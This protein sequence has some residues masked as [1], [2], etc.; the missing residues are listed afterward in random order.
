MMLHCFVWSHPTLCWFGC[1][2][3]PHASSNGA[4]KF[5]LGPPK[6]LFIAIDPEPPAWLLLVPWSASPAARLCPLVKPSVARHSKVLM[7]APCSGSGF[8]DSTLLGLVHP[9]SARQDNAVFVRSFDRPLF[10]TTNHKELWKR[11]AVT[12]RA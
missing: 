5:H 8:L 7:N 9:H 4:F 11:K 12:S 1:T 3:W 2:G 10:F 6:L